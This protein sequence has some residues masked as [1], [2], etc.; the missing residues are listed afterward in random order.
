M[1]DVCSLSKKG[2]LDCGSSRGRSET[3]FLYECRDD[4][5]AH[6]KNCFLSRADLK[7]YEVILQRAGLE[8]LSH[9][10]VKKLRVCPRHRY[11]LG[12]YWRPSKLCQYPGHK[13]TPTS[14]QSRDVINPAIAEEV[15]QLFGISVPIGSRKYKTHNVW[16]ISLS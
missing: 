2:F 13:G 5:T 7:E 16:K 11:G 8:H 4:L 10:Q 12:K 6:L 1:A 15:F 9:E 3:V 14:V